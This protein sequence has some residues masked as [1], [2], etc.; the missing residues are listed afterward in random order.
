MQSEYNY[1]YF[2]ETKVQN[3]CFVKIIEPWAVTQLD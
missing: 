2:R 1:S 3:S